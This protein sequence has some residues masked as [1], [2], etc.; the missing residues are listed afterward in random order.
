V[1]HDGWA[2]FTQ[3]QDDLA[4]AFQAVG[5]ADRLRRVSGGEVIRFA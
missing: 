4:K 3:S 1:H 5:L 2:H